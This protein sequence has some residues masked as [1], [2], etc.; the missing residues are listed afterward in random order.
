MIVAADLDSTTGLQKFRTECAAAGA[1]APALAH[2][3]SRIKA[4]AKLRATVQGFGP[5]NYTDPATFDTSRGWVMWAYANLRFDDTVATFLLQEAEKING[6]G[7]AAL[8][9]TLVQR[10][11]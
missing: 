7:F 11:T 3:D 6:P 5:L 2:M 1:C 4:K 10:Q 9:T 8:A